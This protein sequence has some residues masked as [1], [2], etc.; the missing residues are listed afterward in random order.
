MWE[1]DAALKSGG[2]LGIRTLLECSLSDVFP[3]DRAQQ[4]LEQ[5]ARNV[6]DDS[7]ID[8]ATHTPSPRDRM[9]SAPILRRTISGTCPPP[10]HHPFVGVGA[11]EC[12]R[13]RDQLMNKCSAL[14]PMGALYYDMGIG[15]VS[16]RYVFGLTFEKLNTDQ[17]NQ[18]FRLL[19]IRESLLE[20]VRLRGPA[21]VHKHPYFQYRWR[22]LQ[23]L[24]DLYFEHNDMGRTPQRIEQNLLISNPE[25]VLVLALPGDP[26]RQLDRCANGPSAADA[27]L[28]R[29]TTAL[30]HELTQTRREQS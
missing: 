10:K 27:E 13:F 30:G 12:Q 4:L 3:S 7:D 9:D 24:H 19:L 22:T 23:Q 25:R 16:E 26:A 18:K 5:A 8:D 21:E 11:E 20:R 28:D 29:Y 15:I 1:P 6:N 17:H 2:Q 14:V